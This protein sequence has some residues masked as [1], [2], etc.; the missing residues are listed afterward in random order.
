MSAF[1]WQSSHR[2]VTES[3]AMQVQPVAVVLFTLL[4]KTYRL[5]D[6]EFSFSS[7]NGAH[8]YSKELASAHD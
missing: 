3:E 6:A 4:Q 2:Q 8:S 5:N 7:V 1:F